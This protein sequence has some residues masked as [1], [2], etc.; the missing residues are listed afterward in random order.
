MKRLF[1]TLSA[2][3]L[4]L[5]LILCATACGTK[6]VDYVAQHKFDANSGRAYQEVESI[7]M[8]VDGDTTHF[9]VKDP[10]NGST[11]VKARYLAVN[12]PE[13]TGKIEPYGK[14]ASRFTK[15][16][17]ENA[18]SIIIE[19]DT[20]KWETD[21]TG[22]RVLSWIWYKTDANS[23]YRL[24]NLELL[25]EGLAIASAT[26]SN[27]YGDICM[28]ALNQAQ[29]LKLHA[30][31]GVADPEI[32]TGVPIELTLAELRSNLEFY[33]GCDVA[34]EGVVTRFYN[35]GVYVEDYDERTQTYYAMYVYYGYN[36]S[37]YVMDILKVGNRV[38]I[39]GN[40]QYWEAGGTYQ[41]TDIGYDVWNPDD[42]NNIQFISSGHQG[43]YKLT[44]ADTF[45]NGVV[46]MS[47]FV[48]GEEEWVE[49]KYAKLVMNTSITME[50]LYV[51]KTYTTTNDE[52]AS[53]GAFTLTCKQGNVTVDIRTD[54]LYDA[55][56]NLVTADTYKGKT[57][58][59]RGYVDY[60]DGDYQI[61]VLSVNDLIIQE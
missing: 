57:I 39:V 55:D 24:L 29:E 22:E 46:R 7:K 45:V 47:T 48:D 42:P 58:T 56:G 20:N 27:S 37:G 51:S 61:K 50:N 32:Y 52:S 49:H 5:L 13:S 36:A 16:K 4:A 33:S 30:F 17:L 23:E 35:N 44:D 6:K 14:T 34:F 2:S 11:T 31:S 40:L 59:V 25:Q 10:I 26:A 60:Y 19:S 53:K 8:F 38:K 41:V 43:A 21:S 1:K 15:S 12:T 54:V 9:Y 3:I 18:A 28:K